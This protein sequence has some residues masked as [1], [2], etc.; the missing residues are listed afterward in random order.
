MWFDTL[1]E[2]KYPF[3]KY[4]II[5]INYLK[6]LGTRKNENQA[7]NSTVTEMQ[8]ELQQR[9][10]YHSQPLKSVQTRTMCSNFIRAR[11]RRAATKANIKLCPAITWG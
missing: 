4:I 10:V 8:T 6:I 7:N 3:K 9:R 11:R 1:P 5:I 2:E